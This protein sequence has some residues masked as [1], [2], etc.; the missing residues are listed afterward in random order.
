M[1][2]SRSTSRAASRSPEFVIVARLNILSLSGTSIALRS[3][4]NAARFLR[5]AA[6]SRSFFLR[7]LISLIFLVRRACISD[8]ICSSSASESGSPATPS[9]PD[10][11]SASS[12][13]SSFASAFFALRSS[14]SFS[15][16]VN[17]PLKSA[18]L[19]TLRSL[20]HVLTSGLVRRCPRYHLQLQP[21]STGFSPSFC[22]GTS[23][24]TWHLNASPVQS[25]SICIG[26]YSDPP[27]RK[28]LTL[29]MLRMLASNPV[30]S[31]PFLLRTFFPYSLWK[32]FIL[33]CFSPVWARSPP[34]VAA[35]SVCSKTHLGSN[36]RWSIL[37][38]AT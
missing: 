25:L 18:L 30:M 2:S 16:Q 4:P 23:L 26:S 9:S 5:L 20:R 32:M 36:M 15:R 17:R 38:G 28:S 6:P 12:A 33:A 29:P 3:I 1:T 8:W 19:R 31:Y 13:P 7:R 35:P 14:R 21:G 10:A 11:P 22:L 37:S 24:H 34:P 27:S